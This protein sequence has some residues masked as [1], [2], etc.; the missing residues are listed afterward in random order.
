MFSSY[1]HVTMVAGW[2][3]QQLELDVE[4][5]YQEAFFFCDLIVIFHGNLSFRPCTVMCA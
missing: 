2:Q 3:A 5:V 4:G 1:C